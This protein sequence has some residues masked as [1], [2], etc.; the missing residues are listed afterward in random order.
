MFTQH[1][2]NDIDIQ[3]YYM[4]STQ[5]ILPSLYK[6]LEKGNDPER[7]KGALY[8]LWNKGIGMGSSPLD[9]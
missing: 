8:I 9:L 5:Y 3:Q 7:M 2:P 6:A 1:S 4:R